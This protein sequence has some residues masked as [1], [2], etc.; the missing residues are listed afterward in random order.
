MSSS[1]SRKNRGLDRTDRSILALLQHNARLTNKEIARL[2]NLSPTPCLRRIGMLE[3]AGYVSRYKA[4]LDPAKLGFSIFAFL[5]LKRSR[6]SS[7]ADV[8]R[9]IMEIP[10]VLSCHVV[11]GEFDLMAEVV[12]RDMD[13]Y[14]RITLDH[15]AKMPG[16][17]DL[18]STFSIKALKID[19]LLPIAREAGDAQ[20]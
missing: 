9:R 4:V 3:E 19:G 15:I 12:A 16:I 7:Q 2:V 1:E 10:E 18:R 6:E 20:V 8:A 5:S 17:Y 11:S 14:A 13:D